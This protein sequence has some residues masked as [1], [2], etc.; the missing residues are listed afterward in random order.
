[1]VANSQICVKI[2]R[3]FY[4]IN[5]GQK[6]PDEVQKFWMKTGQY[7]DLIKSGALEDGKPVKNPDHK[8]IDGDEESKKVKGHSKKSEDI[9]EDEI[10]PDESI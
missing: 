2:G 9:E 10:K 6:V 4:R 1:M 8:N 7:K 3:A 5:R